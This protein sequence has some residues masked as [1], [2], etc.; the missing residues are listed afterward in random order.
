M[1]R[2]PVCGWEM[3]KGDIQRGGFACPGCKHR[4][5]IP[6]PS[7]HEIVAGVV[8]GCVLAVLTPYLMGARGNAL[9]GWVIALLLPAGVAFGAAIGIIH[10]LLFPRVEVDPGAGDGTILHLTGPPDPPK[11]E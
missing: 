7:G 6:S 10:G 4:L 9:L 3:Q 11:K 2:C 8:G 5:R 1:A